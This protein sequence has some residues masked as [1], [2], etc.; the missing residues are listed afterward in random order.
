MVCYFG[1][2]HKIPVEF[3]RFLFSSLITSRSV[4]EPKDDVIVC[5]K[6]LPNFMYTICCDRHC[7]SRKT[8]AGIILIIPIETN[9]QVN[10]CGA[11]LCIVLSGDV[12]F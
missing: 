6:D 3:L 10:L 2:L 4:L 5:V 7:A 12:I 1:R 11:H 9:A 8:F